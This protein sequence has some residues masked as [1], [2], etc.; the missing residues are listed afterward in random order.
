[1]SE[2]TKLKSVSQ[3]HEQSN[4][5]FKPA[6]GP[7]TVK[8]A[9]IKKS[10]LDEAIG[11]FSEQEKKAVRPKRS[12][13]SDEGSVLHVGK[14]ARGTI[15]TDTKSKQW[16]IASSIKDSVGGWFSGAQEKIEKT[17]AK[18]KPKKVMAASSTRT[19][20]IK[21]AAAS[22]ALASNDGF[23]SVQ[24]ARPIGGLSKAQ[25]SIRI[26]E[27]NVP[28]EIGDTR[29]RWTHVVASKDKT[30][31]QHEAKTDAAPE[32]KKPL[33]LEAPEAA[34]ALSQ[35]KKP[36][37]VQKRFRSVKTA[38][39]VLV[40]GLKL[41]H[42]PGAEARRDAEKS[43][44]A[45][46]SKPVATDHTETKSV[47]DA[48]APQPAQVEPDATTTTTAPETNESAT[49][50]ITQDES[51]TETSPTSSRKEQGFPI[52]TVVLVI[53]FISSL[54]ISTTFL[55]NLSTTGSL[56]E[57]ETTTDTQSLIVA[58]TTTPVAFEL[59]EL[60]AAAERSSGLTVFSTNSEI[61]ALSLIK[62]W[63]TSFTLYA[64]AAEIGALG[65]APFVIIK[66]DSLDTALAS[67]LAAEEQLPSSL[68][69][70][71]TTTPYQTFSESTS[72]RNIRIGSDGLAYTTT[73]EG[74]VVIATSAEA[75]E[76]L[77]RRIKK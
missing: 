47:P 40:S 72:N 19:T 23:K 29:P 74:I 9:A 4:T 63:N 56:V 43:E 57:T 68:V 3:H 37:N 49:A 77:L 48:P 38:R 60:T 26:K 34:V 75:I 6:T 52:I 76:S 17:L 36:Q 62:E 32:N 15:I 7:L 8:H 55:R 59:S 69:K 64:T 30:E 51:K 53:L 73:T 61:D 21:K 13:L 28:K 18:P 31:N 10:Q 65:Q 39:P 24:P 67:M 12:L 42:T 54:A 5:G 66:T 41:S 58:D 50:P 35:I 16:N 22:S 33:L 44:P 46:I 70:L 20:T 14:E 1:M 11:D 25:S 45:K 27:K 71:F 2:D